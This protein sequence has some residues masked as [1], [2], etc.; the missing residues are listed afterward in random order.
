MCSFAA[1]LSPKV[2]DFGDLPMAFGDLPV[3]V[4]VPISRGREPARSGAGDE[5]ALPVILGS[6]VNKRS[7]SD[8]WAILGSIVIPGRPRHAHFA[9]GGDEELLAMAARDAFLLRMRRIRGRDA[10]ICI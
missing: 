4:R 5:E 1:A 7:P 10:P 3:P 2:G 6:M 8:S 9:D